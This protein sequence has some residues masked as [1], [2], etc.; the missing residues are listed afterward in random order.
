MC[1]GKLLFGHYCFQLLFVYK[2]LS[3]VSFN[4][5][6]LEDKRLSSKFLRKWGWFQGYNKRFP[7]KIKLLKTDTPCCRWNSTDNNSLNMSHSLENPFTFYLAKEITR[8]LIFS[9]NDKLSQNLTEKQIM[10]SKATINWS[11]SDI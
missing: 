1:Y 5:F 9:T 2:T 10:L 7:S 8:K 6:F 3:Q 4:L 11:F